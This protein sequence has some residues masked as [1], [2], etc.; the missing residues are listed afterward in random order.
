M[1][2]PYH[3]AIIMDGNGRWA[4]ARNL[5]RNAGHREGIKRL[6]E[7]IK[8][9]QKAGV[10]IVTVFA[11]STENWNRPKKELSFL[12]SYL[13][14]FIDSYKRELIEKG[15]R[16]KAIGR[17]DRIGEKIVRKIEAVEKI[18]RDNNKLIFNIALDYGGRWDILG[19]VRGI[20]KDYSCKHFK[21]S[22]IDEKFFKNY[23]SLGEFPEPDLLIRTSGESR[24]SNFLI[25]DLAYS[26]FY[27]TSLFWPDFDSKQ[28]QKAI[29]VYSERERRFGRIDE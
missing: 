8:A 5:P 26:E 2:V 25:W 10:K 18:T 20:I 19:A 16:F 22:D 27:F 23:L 13:E 12:F 11:F 14:K 6:K 21:A 15:I 29:K 1:N 9:A 7:I 3:I 28:F 24:I 17:R 4:R